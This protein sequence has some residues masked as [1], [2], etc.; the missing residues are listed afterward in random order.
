MGVSIDSGGGGGGRK[1]V[2]VEM[3]L[4]PFIDMM[5][6]LVAF[7]LIT[8]AWVNLASIK[9]KPGGQGQ[10]APDVPPPANP[11]VEMS[12]LIANDGFWLGTTATPPEK[13]DKMGED[14]NWAALEERLQWYKADSGHFLEKDNIQIAAEDKVTYQ[15]I[16]TA[17]DTSIAKKFLGVQ[18]MDPAALSV[19]FKQ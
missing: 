13:I 11:P 1:S 14:Y 6:C 12:V 19:R 18:F 9:T 3:N 7:L 10:T 17:M 8:A 15:T 16:I 4:V 2:D 5:S